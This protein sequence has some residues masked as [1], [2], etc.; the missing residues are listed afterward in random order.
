VAGEPEYA[1]LDFKEAIDFFKQKVNVPS[2]KWADIRDGAHARAFTVAGATKEGM[3]TDFRSAIDSAI[4]NGTTLEDF[5]K[6]FDD[7]VART[8]WEHAG[9][10]DWRSKLIFNTN[11]S[12]AYAAGR[13][14]QMTDPDVLRVMPYWRY[15]HSD[16]VDHPRP[17]HLAWDGLVLRHDDKWWSSHYAPNGWGCQ[18]SVEPMTE[19]QLQEMGKHGP[20]KAPADEPRDVT[21]NTSA[22][23]VTISVPKGIDPGWGYSVG[24]ANTGK[25]LSEQQMNAWRD[26]GADAWESMTPG[27]WRSAGQP[28]ALSADIPKA[29]P[30]APAKD[31]AVLQAAIERA[32]GGKSAALMT[33][34]GDSV[35][36]DAE[37][38]ASHMP[39]D[40]ARWVPFLPE[41]VSDP[42]EIWLRFERHKGTGRVVLR[43][44]LIKLIQLEQRKGLLL[45][46]QSSGGSLDAWTMLPVSDEKYLQSQRVGKLLW[47]RP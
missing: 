17:E 3:L 32:I 18:C 40:R 21:L 36:I 26:Q 15:R 24:E 45:V 34:T 47:K 29:S 28:A 38:L 23:P 37:A 9:S 4:S 35:G 25:Q 33:P 19:R 41:L 16:N 7:V 27:D 11:L 43:Q 2:A 6:K 10:R 31:Q 39:P 14:D 13:H 30:I 1:S 5:R 22:G 8:G 44:R 20:D 12:T 42:A 46:L